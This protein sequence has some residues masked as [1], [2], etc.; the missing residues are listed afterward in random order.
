MTP[1]SGAFALDVLEQIQAVAVRQIDIEQHEIEE[2][3]FNTPQPFF[4]GRGDIRLISLRAR[5]CCETF[6]NFAFHRQ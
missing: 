5:S 2:A 4:A 1:S 6:A 3:V